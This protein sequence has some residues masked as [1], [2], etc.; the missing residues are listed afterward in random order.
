[1]SGFA[2]HSEQL[3]MITPGHSRRFRDVRGSSGY[4][5]KRLRRCIANLSQLHDA[6]AGVTRACIEEST[7]NLGVHKNFCQKLSGTLATTHWKPREKSPAST[8]KVRIPN[9]VTAIVQNAA[10]IRPK[11]RRPRMN[12]TTRIAA[13]TAITRSPR[14]IFQ[15]G[16]LPHDMLKAAAIWAHDQ[17]HSA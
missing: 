9:T 12:M 3:R 2:V 4:L 14:A 16:R 15:A 5:R 6:C 1:M 10:A 11:A 8:T 17:T 7:S 13:R